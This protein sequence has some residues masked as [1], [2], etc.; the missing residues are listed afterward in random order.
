MGFS[1]ELDSDVEELPRGDQAVDVFFEQL[2][3]DRNTLAGADFGH[4][5]FGWQEAVPPD[6][7]FRDW[8]TGIHQRLGGHLL[9][10][11]GEREQ[12]DGQGEGEKREGSADTLDA[13]SLGFSHHCRSLFRIA[14]GSRRFRFRQG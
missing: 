7:H 13:R 5:L 1:E 11:G 8:F 2:A 10:S 14:S 12:E 9:S 4:D 6:P 3:I